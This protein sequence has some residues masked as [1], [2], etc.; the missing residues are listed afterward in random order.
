MKKRFLLLLLVLLLAACQPLGTP[1]PSITPLPTPTELPSAT[2]QPTA[3]FLPTSQPTA[4]ATPQPTA[5]PAIS[6]PL[7][8]AFNDCALLPALASCGGKLP[9][10]G[11][12]A[13]SDS[14]NKRL[15]VVDFKSGAAWQVPAAAAPA[16][17]S[18]SP[19]GK[20]LASF[21]PGNSAQ[22]YLIYDSSSGKEVQQITPQ[23]S[24]AWTPQ[25]SF[26]GAGFRT[27][28]SAAGDLAWIDFNTALAHIRF[29][30]QPDKEVTWPVGPGP[31]DQIP[32]AVTWV[33]GSD[34]LLFEQH[35]AANSMWVSGGALYTLNV[36]TGEVQDLKANMLLD[37]KFQWHPA[38]KGVMVFG[39]SSNSSM[40]GGQA[41]AVLNVLTG[42]ISHPIADP[43]V[44]ISAP[45]WLQ[46]GKTILFSAFMPGNTA[47]VG[48]PF[49]LPAIYTINRDGSGAHTV[50]KPSQNERDSHLQFL[51]DGQHFL[52]FRSDTQKG[53]FTLRLAAVDSSLD[54]A[55]TG[56][57]P[58]QQCAFVCF[59]DAVVVYQP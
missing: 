36:K 20:L 12:L 57:L 50:T 42:Q 28:W 6:G 16:G 46:D 49:A 23:G 18:F 27:V 48:D 51:P 47:Q 11:R 39:D 24:D 33:P 44:S 9:L 10:S 40:M 56:S 30:A 8:A 52:Y 31:S 53:T 55:V 22:P 34:L 43:N 2:P 54:E 58:P 14:A 13:L 35:Y 29:A 32:Q 7:A 21:P 59:S 3:T 26:E 4:T 17:L 37:F 45:A 25:D 41:L 38:E 1:L 5:T 15:V 19:S